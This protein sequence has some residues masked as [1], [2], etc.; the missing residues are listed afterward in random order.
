MHTCAVVALVHGSKSCS[1]PAVQLQHILLAGIYAVEAE[2][3][4]TV[5]RDEA[6][7][8]STCAQAADKVKLSRGF[9]RTDAPRTTA[10]A[11][12]QGLQ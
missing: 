4:C 12:E 5:N 1:E 2:G 10:P 3:I 8:V 9:M 11:G 7:M 6:W